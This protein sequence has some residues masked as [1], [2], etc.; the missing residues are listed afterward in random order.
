MKT[1][2]ILFLIGFCLSIFGCKDNTEKPEDS[3]E[4]AGTGSVTQGLATTTTQNLLDCGRVAGV[5]TIIA[6][7]N[8]TWIVPSEVNYAN[9]TF[10]FASVLNNPCMNEGYASVSEALEALDG[11]DIVEIDADGEVITT[12]IFTDNYFEMYI[13]GIPVGK[14]NVP[15]TEFNSDLVRFKVEKPFTVAMKLVDWE[16]NLGIGTENNGG[17]S[18]HPGDGGLVAV[19]TDQNLEIIGITDATWKAQTFYVAPIKDLSCLSESGGSRLSTNC[20]TA[21]SNDGSAYY[22]VHWTLTGNWMNEDFEDSTWPLAHIYTNQTIGVDNKL[23]YTN[24]TDMFD[25]P[26]QDAQFIWSSNVIL[27]N[28]V[29]VRKTFN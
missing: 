11:S 22:G 20:D 21:G 2:P 4:Y 14:D 24:Y 8:T 10:P 18:H 25:D 27:D 7:D 16:E 17:S 13:N 9:A 12:I 19:F 26:N 3:N 6:T 15:F 23:S 5:G 28:E 29:I 1:F